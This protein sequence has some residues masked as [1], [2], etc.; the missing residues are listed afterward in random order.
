MLVACEVAALSIS[1]MVSGASSREVKAMNHWLRSTQHWTRG[2]INTLK[3]NRSDKVPRP[4]QSPAV[5]RNRASS[6]S[7]FT[8]VKILC[9]VVTSSKF[10]PDSMATPIIP[11]IFND[12]EGNVQP[13]ITN[14]TK[15]E[16]KARTAL[17][18][19]GRVTSVSSSARCG[20]SK[21]V[22]C[23]LVTTLSISDLVVTQAAETTMD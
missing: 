22:E 8:T 2:T 6:D 7:S 11:R 4:I 10:P 19:Q 15:Q 17:F 14:K 21:P 18:T 16:A 20:L 3:M 1:P 23:K 5:L 12:N 13:R 9:R